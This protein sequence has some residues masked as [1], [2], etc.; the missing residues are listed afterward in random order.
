MM[1][2]DDR[3]LVKAAS[4][5]LGYPDRG[6]LESIDP[7]R[8]ILTGLPPSSVAAMLLD[9]ASSLGRKPLLQ[10]QEEYTRL[11]DL[12]ASTSLNLT[13][14]KWGDGKDRGHALT[15]FKQAYTR[16]GF[17]LTGGE[18]PDYLPM[19]FEFLAV[20]DDEAFLFLVG[21]Y[22]ETLEQLARRLDEAGSAH[23]RCLWAVLE[24]LGKN[25]G[26]QSHD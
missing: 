23:A 17:S 21:E 4:F 10:L 14:H 25:K 12:G 6:W 2:E 15:C 24:V 1:T 22:E 26:G 19:V 8:E 20:C 16:A 9:A 3:T 5:L 18:L 7:V 13:Y 11:F